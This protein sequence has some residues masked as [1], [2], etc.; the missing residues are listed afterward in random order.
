MTHREPSSMH[1][2]VGAYLL[3]ALDAG[4][5][6]AFERHLEGCAACRE[7]IGRLRPAME[8]LPRSVEPVAPSPG[9]KRELLARVREESTSKASP[10]LGRSPRRVL[11]GLFARPRAG[12]AWAGAAVLLVCGALG[13]YAVSQL[14]DENGGGDRRVLSAQIDRSAL[15]DASASL[16]VPAGGGPAE[17]RV[18]NMRLPRPGEVYEMW[19]RRRGGVEPAGV[20]TVTRD[21]NGRATVDGDLSGSDQVMVT[22]ER[23]GGVRRPT[24]APV[25]SVR[26]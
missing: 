15:P 14:S 24:G 13:G 22:R 26:L 23:A 20:F 21:G 5:A 6:R 8:A 25:L 4:E 17:L 3:G 18:K 10:A 11:G 12:V 2:D 9:V 1:D 16:V 19:L 7:E